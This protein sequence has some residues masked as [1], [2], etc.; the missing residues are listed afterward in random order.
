M[1]VLMATHDYALIKKFPAK[2]LRCEN[3]KVIESDSK[4]LFVEHDH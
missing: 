1:A 4:T 3:G 2:T